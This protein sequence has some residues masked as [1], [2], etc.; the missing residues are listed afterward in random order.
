[1]P[2]AIL[3]AMAA[4]RAVVATNVG[5]VAELVTDGETGYLIEEGDIPGF[6][7]AVGRLLANPDQ[8]RQ[9]G[10]RG[11]ERIKEKFSCACAA[12]RFAKRYQAGLEESGMGLSNHTERQDDAQTIR[13][14]PSSLEWEK[15]ASN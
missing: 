9:M 12:A 5:G 14:K 2:N 15:A 1:M 8:A 4:A 13:E 7:E 6:A 11:R 10:I 3:E